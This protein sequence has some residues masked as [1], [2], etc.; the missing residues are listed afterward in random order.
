VKRGL[1]LVVQTGIQ[2]KI[3]RPEVSGITGIGVKLIF[4][5]RGY[6]QIPALVDFV[7]K[8]NPEVT[9]KIEVI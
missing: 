3:I 2:S 6:I 5:H 7:I 9:T 1:K 4:E 8:I